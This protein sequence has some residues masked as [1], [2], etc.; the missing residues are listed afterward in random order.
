MVLVC[1]CSLG[2]SASVLF[3]ASLTKYST[4]CPVK[5]GA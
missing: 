2:E 1:V 3:A 5:H 4:K